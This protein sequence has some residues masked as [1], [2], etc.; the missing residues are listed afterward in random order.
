MLS[1]KTPPPTAATPLPVPP[2]A[3]PPPAAQ[4]AAAPPSP[5]A[6]RA[7]SVPQYLRVTRWHDPR[8]DH[9]SHDPRSAYVE[10]FWM[11]VLGPSVVWFLRLIARE[12]DSNPAVD[13]HLMLDLPLTARRLG[14]GFKGGRN[15]AFMRTL[16]RSVTFGMARRPAGSADALEVRTLVPPMPATLHDRLPQ[17]LRAEMSAWSR[18]HDGFELSGGETR[19]LASCMLN[20]GH[21]L[22]ESSERI[23]M[24]GVSP[25]AANQAVAWAWADKVHSRPQ[26]GPAAAG[27]LTS[28]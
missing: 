15:S 7:A 3:T 23:V 14:L 12:F 13:A 18:T 19:L 9:R 27:P 20:M 22:H 11:S 25:D 26:R 24:L 10:R 1:P 2:P 16:D 6:R 28:V 5:G 8:R 21:G 17:E 4:P